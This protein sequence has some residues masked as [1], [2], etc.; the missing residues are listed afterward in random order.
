MKY[1]TL[2]AVTLFASGATAD[3]LDILANAESLG[4]DVMMQSRGGNY[5]LNID[6]IY[7][8]S[9]MDG[10]VA[11]NS[12]DNTWTGDNIIDSGSFS[13]TSGIVSVVQNTGNNVLIQ[14]ATVVN[15]TLK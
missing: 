1:L 8:S 11:N 4:D 15:L 9:D 5:E 3:G 7:A 6:N 2:I 14:N 12:A 13:D 10:V